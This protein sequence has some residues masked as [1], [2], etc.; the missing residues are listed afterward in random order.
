[1]PA[2]ARSVSIAFVR[3]AL[4]R[5]PELGRAA[6]LQR[7]GIPAAALADDAARVSASAF[8]ALW[9]AVAREIDDEFFGL[10][11]RRMKPGS[12]ALL[13]H[14]LAG[15]ATVDQ[16][17]RLAVRGFNLFFDD[18]Q[19][20]LALQGREARLVLT[21]AAQPADTQTEAQT[22]VQTAAEADARRFADETLLIMLHGL[23]CWLAGARVPVARLEMAHPRPP[24]ADEYRRMFS[25]QMRFD[26]P[27]TLL[28]FDPRA[29]GQRAAVDAGALKAFLRDAP[30]SVFMKQV[31]DAHAAFGERVRRRLRRAG[32]HWP[33][34]DTLAAELRLSPATLRRRLQAEGTSWRRLKDELRHERA[35][36]L[37]GE[38]RLSVA[39]VASRLG[40]ED[41]SAFYRAF[42]RRMGVG[43]GA[44][45][46]SASAENA[47]P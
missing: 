31:A 39:E 28:A 9:L 27:R 4:Q 7:C 19:A 20:S 24:H 11:A 46:R 37:L 30:S 16:G 45:R 44:F 17:L 42:R 25:P 47:S 38:G 22:K 36:L 18:V 10:D 15:A 32:S 1:M 5:V 35:A 6:L 23:L 43:P 13:C 21:P 3:S 34:L 12:F 2:I 33:T 26:A 8:G 41:A 29:L 14:A 40:Y